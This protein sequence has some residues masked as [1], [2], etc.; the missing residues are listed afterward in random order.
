LQSSEFL[1]GALQT[2]SFEQVERWKYLSVTV[3]GNMVRGVE[4]LK[5]TTDPA[6]AHGREDNARDLS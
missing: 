5:S 1:W 3:I 6:S 2:A 4:Q